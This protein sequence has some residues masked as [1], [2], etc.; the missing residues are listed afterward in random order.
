[1][2]GKRP[3]RICRKW[4]RPHP[5]VG[6]RQRVCSR[7]AC[8]RE[9]H[10]RACALWR[11]RNPDYDRE[12]RLQA[13][14]RRDPPPEAADSPLCGSPVQQL[15][16]PAARD[17]VGLEVAVVVEVALRLLTA[18]VRDGVIV[19][20]SKQQG[21]TAQ[22]LSGVVRDEIVRGARGR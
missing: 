10:R 5:R 19:Q 16:W 1:M 15:D 2:R 13:K 12:T 11:G 8:Q 9:R 22:H 6:T 17:A 20:R 18:W 14:L 3:C 7:A 21:V 4:F